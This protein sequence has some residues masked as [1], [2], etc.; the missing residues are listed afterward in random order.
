MA[1]TRPS[2]ALDASDDNRSSRRRLVAAALVAVGALLISAFAMMS[3]RAAYS[4]PPGYVPHSA[5]IN[6]DSVTGNT[7]TGQVALR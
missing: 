1:T 2:L 3:E 6:G 5:L 7:V 4:A